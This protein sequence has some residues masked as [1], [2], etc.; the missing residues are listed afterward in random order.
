MMQKKGRRSARELMR[1]RVLQKTAAGVAQQH[2]ADEEDINRSTV[3]DICNRF[4][5][6]RL[7]R[8]LYDAPRSGQP[9]KLN[10][11]AVAHLIAMACSAAPKGRDHWTLALLQQQM[12]ADKQVTN[13]STVAIWHTMKE[14]DIKP[15]LEKNVVH[16]ETHARIH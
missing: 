16:P 15:W 1:G 9:K 2:I 8:A 14:H 3:A 13:I 11:K 4:D 10:E 12:I 7:Q 6:G 5:H